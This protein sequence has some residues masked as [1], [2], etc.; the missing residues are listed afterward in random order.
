M[1]YDLGPRARQVY[2]VLL[3]RIRSG[4]LA[5]GTRLPAHT[6][7]AITFSVAPLTMRQVLAR[8]EAEGLV[9]RERGRGT[10]VRGVDRPDVLILARSSAERALLGA[11]VS[12]A[13]RHALLAA[14]PAEG[15]AALE[16]EP[17]L[18]LV[19]LDL[20]LPMA[21][22]G[23]RFVRTV[24]RLR[25]S[26]VIAVV[27]PT[28]RQ[29]SRLEHIVASPLIYLG[30]PV[31]THLV[32]L[33][34][35][36]FAGVHGETDASG[37]QAGLTEP[38]AY[39]TEHY[40]ALQLAGERGAARQL[41]LRDGLAAG[42]SVEDLYLRVLQ[43][44]QH[45]I[46]ELWQHNQITVAREHLATA[47][48]GSV[49][50]ELAAAAPRAPTTEYS[51]LVAC[52]E[53]ELHDLGA[54]MVADLLELDGF[55]V[56]FLGANVPTD[57]LLEMLQAERPRLLVL[58]ATMSERLSQLR[59]AITGVRRLGGGQLPVFVGGQALAWVP[60]P[61]R[62]LDVELAARDARETVHAARRLRAIDELG[63]TRSSP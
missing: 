46:G 43:P 4:E 38:M 62:G 2:D 59:E 10:F 30:Q 28:R 35:S 37:P 18:V 12:E 20:A 55:V 34:R 21:S 25:P 31:S 60:N 48:T 54:R 52:V 45:R 42:A 26:L 15:L 24:R 33:L 63:S 22:V 53:G 19:L 3:D 41:I 13:G 7:L 8:L 6:E 23:L 11:Q 56:R 40:L 9:A 14:T 32:Q 51:A 16:R 39:L 47:V 17:A 44:A 5:S 29:K 57:S 27:N 49:V 58:S 1:M 36:E 61:A 50:A